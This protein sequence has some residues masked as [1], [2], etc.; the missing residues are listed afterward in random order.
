MVVCK[1]LEDTPEQDS[2]ST[3]QNFLNSWEMS[4]FFRK[5]WENIGNDCL[6]GSEVGRRITLESGS[7]MAWDRKKVGG[8]T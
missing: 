5:Q 7:T 3:L 8:S 2:R 6:A 1:A 4:L